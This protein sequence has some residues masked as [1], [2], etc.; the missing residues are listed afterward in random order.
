VA[1]LAMVSEYDNALLA[2]LGYVFLDLTRVSMTRREEHP[3][4]K[5]VIRDNLTDLRIVINVL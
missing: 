3:R 4:T 1:D 5:Q 2:M